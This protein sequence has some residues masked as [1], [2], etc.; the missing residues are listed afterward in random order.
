MLE[1]TTPSHQVGDKPHCK[2]LHKSHCCCSTNSCTRLLWHCSCRVPAYQRSSSCCH[3][4]PNQLSSCRCTPARGAA[5]PCMSHQQHAL[6]CCREWPG[7][8]QGLHDRQQGRRAA[9]TT[10]RQAWHACIRCS[11]C[12][13]SRASHV[14]AHAQGVAVDIEH[15][16]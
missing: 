10:G 11:H 7:T 15:Q 6:C 16:G 13:A 2:S 5:G 14:A 9:H 4:T 8:R 3:P 1:P 12:L